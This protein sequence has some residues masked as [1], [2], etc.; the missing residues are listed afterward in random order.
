MQKILTDIV[1]HLSQ[2]HQQ[3]ARVLEAKRQV[4]ERMAE[5]VRGIPDFQPELNGPEGWMESSI[6]VTKS[7]TAYLN[8]L[9]EL[10]ES[11]GDS[12]TN[13]VRAMRTETEEE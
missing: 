4:A 9:A 7:I 8:G 5:L 6:Q 12:L 2:S 1:V 3:L 11:A 10:E 13:V